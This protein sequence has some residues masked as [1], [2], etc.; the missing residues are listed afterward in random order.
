[1][2][3][4]CLALV[5]LSAV[6]AAEYCTG[7]RSECTNSDRLPASETIETIFRCAG[8]HRP[9]KP[10]DAVDRDMM[11]LKAKQLRLDK[12]L[13]QQT[14]PEPAHHYLALFPRNNL[15]RFHALV[16]SYYSGKHASKCESQ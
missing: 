11:L 4:C 7:L 3:G 16:R 12:F 5:L 9:L 13:E 6:S 1:M 15:V 14:D 10:F 8:L 2:T